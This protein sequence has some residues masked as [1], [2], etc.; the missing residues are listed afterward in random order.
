MAYVLVLHSQEERWRVMVLC[1]VFRLHEGCNGSISSSLVCAA[2]RVKQRPIEKSPSLLFG[3]Q[4]VFLDQMV[5]PAVVSCFFEAVWLLSGPR[6]CDRL[7]GLLQRTM[8]LF[9]DV[10]RNTSLLDPCYCH[11]HTHTC[12][13]IHTSVH[14]PTPTHTISLSLLPIVLMFWLPLSQTI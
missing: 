12:R 9:E 7:K 10:K 14:A 1:E 4:G 11:R 6:L 5:C 13:Y 8:A 2:E 3:S